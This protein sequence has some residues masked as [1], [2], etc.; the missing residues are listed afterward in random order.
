LRLD[1]IAQ[2]PADLAAFLST[3]AVVDRPV[4]DRTGLQGRY[5]FTLDL[6]EAARPGRPDDAPSVSTVLQ[7]QLGLRFEARRSPLEVWVIDHA[8][9]PR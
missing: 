4:I 8:Q 2:T 6:N 7:E 5:T 3:L 9:K 1:F